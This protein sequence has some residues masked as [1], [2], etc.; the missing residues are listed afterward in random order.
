MI[1]RQFSERERSVRAGRQLPLF[2]GLLP[3]RRD[4]SAFQRLAILILNHTENT[5]RCLGLQADG[6]SANQ[7]C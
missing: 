4:G 5:C 1:G 7:N 6:R 2:S 3:D